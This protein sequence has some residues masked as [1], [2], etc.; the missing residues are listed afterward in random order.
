MER[1]FG[2][3]RENERFVNTEKDNRVGEKEKAQKIWLEE[4]DGQALE[5][6]RELI[7]S[8]SEELTFTDEVK[9]SDGDLALSE[10]V[11]AED[12]SENGFFL[13][14]AEKRAEEMAPITG[15]EL[16][17]AYS[18]TVAYFDLYR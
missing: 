1:E 9:A 15:K 17:E 11:D 12:P 7:D 10:E 3:F 8:E 2:K 5:R 4:L 13:H 18:N 14:L 6:T 16:L